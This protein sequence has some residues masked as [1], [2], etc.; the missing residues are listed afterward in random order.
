MKTTRGLSLKSKPLLTHPP[1]VKFAALSDGRIIDPE[2]YL[3]F[4]GFLPPEVSM[5]GPPMSG[6]SAF[7]YALGLNEYIDSGRFCKIVEEKNLVYHLDRVR[8][9]DIVVY[10]G[11]DN[12]IFPEVLHAAIAV[13]EDRVRSL[14]VPEG[15]VF[16]H[17]IRE[18]LPVHQRKELGVYF[19]Q[20]RG[21]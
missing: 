10:L 17:P 2:H 8:R 1:E 5:V 7:G 6:V 15:P 14:L 9:N 21:S 3:E 19:A 13:A 4:A 11:Y 20:F 18:V 12:G 16:E